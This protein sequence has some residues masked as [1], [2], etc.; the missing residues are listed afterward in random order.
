MISWITVMLIK[1]DWSASWNFPIFLIGK[2][3]CQ[4]TGWSRKFSQEVNLSVLAL[5]VSE[6][7]TD[8]Q[9]PHKNSSTKYFGI[10]SFFKYCSVSNQCCDLSLSLIG[11]VQ[12]LKYFKCISYLVERKAWTAPANM[13]RTDLQESSTVKPL[14]RPEDLEPVEV[15]S[16]RK[17]PKTLSR[18]RTVQNNFFTS[19][20]LINAVVGGL[21]PAGE[22]HTK[23]LNLLKLPK[24]SS[25]TKL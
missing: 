12:G 22:S 23:P 8:L 3:N 4:S 2:T 1:T 20:S 18:P 25:Y 5:K 24:N 9:K 11:L 7:M 16:T 17:T 15:V 6:V 19:S 10:F 21:S 14:I 13:Q